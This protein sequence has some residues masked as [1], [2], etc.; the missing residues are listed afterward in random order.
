[1]NQTTESL[2][3][4]EQ[5]VNRLTWTES[6]L[7]HRFFS[8]NTGR[9]SIMPELPLDPFRRS[10]PPTFMENSPPWASSFSVPSSGSAFSSSL[11]VT[12]SSSPSGSRSSS[13]GVGSVSASSSWGSAS[14]GHGAGAPF[15]SASWHGSCAD[16]AGSV[17]IRSTSAAS[18][19]SSYSSDQRGAR[20]AANTLS[21]SGPPAMRTFLSPAMAVTTHSP[22]PLL[23]TLGASRPS[24]TPVLRQGRIS[25]AAR[26]VKTLSVVHIDNSTPSAPFNPDGLYFND[27]RPALPTVVLT[28]FE[29]EIP[30][31]PSLDFQGDAG[32]NKL[33]ILWSDENGSPWH[34]N[35]E[36]PRL[37]IIM[38]KIQG[39]PIALKYWADVYQRLGGEK[40]KMWEKIKTMWHNWRYIICRWERSSNDA[41]FWRGLGNS[42]L[43]VHQIGSV[44][45]MERKARDKEDVKRAH[46]EY[47]PEGSEPF[48]TAF[49]RR[50]HAPV[51][52][53]PTDVAKRYREL[54]AEKARVEYGAAFTD[55]FTYQGRHGLTVMT[56]HADIAQVYRQRRE[57]LEALGPV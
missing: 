26:A 51:L 41:E 38:P 50:P 23:S 5:T 48:R 57:L 14:A 25:N 16:S 24:S 44:L 35:S 7:L 56:D 33:V 17:G 27:M 18:S 22:S 42:P 4:L 34:T 6:Q 1:M 13:A 21:F 36:A 10:P 43:S 8:Q 28:F 45:L 47:G 29:D 37:R 40:A 39:R 15:S 30:D 11:A 53:K 19:S 49:T 32:F 9:M 31:P 54:I 20:S 55:V 12:S 3:R 52:S 2:T 46:E